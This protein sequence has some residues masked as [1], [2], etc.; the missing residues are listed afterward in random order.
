M[1]VTETS[2]VKLYDNLLVVTPEKSTDFGTY[3]CHVSDGVT[4]TKCSISLRPGC[5]ETGKE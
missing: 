1:T 5:N 3:E 2:N 4:I